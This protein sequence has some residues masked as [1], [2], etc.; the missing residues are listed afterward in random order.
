MIHV[1]RL[2]CWGE[3]QFTKKLLEIKTENENEN[4]ERDFT[5]SDEKRCEEKYYAAVDRM[6]RECFGLSDN[7]QTLLKAVCKGLKHIW[8]ADIDRGK[9]GRVIGASN[10]KR[11]SEEISCINFLSQIFPKKEDRAL[12]LKQAF[13]EIFEKIYGNTLQSEGVMFFNG[14]NHIS[15]CKYAND[16][17]VNTDKQLKLVVNNLDNLLAKCSQEFRAKMN[18]MVTETFVEP[19]NWE[20]KLGFFRAIGSTIQGCKFYLSLFV[21]LIQREQKDPFLHINRSP[22]LVEKLNTM[23]FELHANR[24]NLAQWVQI[25]ETLIRKNDNNG[26]PILPREKVEKSIRDLYGSCAVSA[27]KARGKIPFRMM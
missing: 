20:E 1:S 15:R 6:E 14:V 16:N 27:K 22:N 26:G 10:L 9:R 25:R 19:R 24:T 11:K 17:G 4:N 23:F 5:E 21:E 8:K 3:H 2:C 18:H 7:M 13:W 12:G